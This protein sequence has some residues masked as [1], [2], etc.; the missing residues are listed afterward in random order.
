MD[1]VGNDVVD[2]RDSRCR[3]KS[4]DARFLERVFTSEEAGVI[5]DAP[6]ADRA[7][8]SA[9]AAKEAAFK[10]VTKLLGSPPPFQHSAFRFRPR[11]S[12]PGGEGTVTYRSTEIPVL[13]QHRP[14]RI[15]ALAWHPRTPDPGRLHE[16]V[17]ILPGPVPTGGAQWK[18]SLRG[19]FTER[20]WASVHRPASALVRLN[21]RAHLSRLLDMEEG[22]I[23]IV[24]D[25][26][27]PG[28][29]PPRVLLCGDPW[30]GDVSFSHHGRFLAWAF[31]RPE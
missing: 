1:R 8:W 11:K 17:K 25:A 22:A 20:E 2:L 12:G 21:A 13:I 14:D 10:V 15:H 29:M 24:C 6:D 9:W 28:R 30:Q 16:E 4:S 3:G 31:L 26:G 27:L 5:H 19:R 7:L 23:E 18:G